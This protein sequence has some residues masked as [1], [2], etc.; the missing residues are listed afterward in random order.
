MEAKLKK[1]HH[2]DFESWEPESQHARVDQ[3]RSSPTRFT[4]EETEAENFK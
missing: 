1:K 3:E 2:G 4:D